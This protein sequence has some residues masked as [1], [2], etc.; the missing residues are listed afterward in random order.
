MTGLARRLGRSVVLAGA[1]IGA[2]LV[3]GSA[4]AQQ[5]ATAIALEQVNVEATATRQSPTGPIDGYVA[6]QTLTG[7]KTDTP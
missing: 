3:S 6:R 4:R 7:S 5:A 1:G 2:I